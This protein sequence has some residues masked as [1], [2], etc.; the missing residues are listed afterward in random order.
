MNRFAEVRN[1]QQGKLEERLPWFSFILPPWFETAYPMAAANLR[2][3]IHRLTTPFD[4]YPTLNSVLVPPPF[5]KGNISHRSISLFQ[6]VSYSGYQISNISRI[7]ISNKTLFTILIIK[8]YL[9]NIGG[10]F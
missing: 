3:N 2:H 10:I 4:I 7:L 6:E 8:F 1:T 5:I 9:L